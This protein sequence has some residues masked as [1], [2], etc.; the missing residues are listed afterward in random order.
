M[1]GD[2]RGACGGSG[3]SPR[4]R[5]RRRPRGVPRERHH[6]PGR[7]RRAATCQQLAGLT[8]TTAEASEAVGGRRMRPTTVPRGG[9]GRRAAARHTRVRDGRTRRTW[10]R[11][12]RACEPRASSTSPP[13]HRH[14]PP[15]RP[16]RQRS[17][18]AERGSPASEGATGKEGCD[19]TRS[20]FRS[21]PP[22]RSSIV[23]R[24][25][26]THPP[27][28]S[29]RDVARLTVHATEPTGAPGDPPARETS[30]R[31]TSIPSITPRRAPPRGD[32]SNRRGS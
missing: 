11:C 27:I 5:R 32:P 6:R 24:L 14:P 29:S 1:G 4:G 17:G 3:R 19:V 13:R 7:P 8:T 30:C 10:P 21:D 20:P 16:P 15:R 2:G 31:K 26:A 22:P 18:P 25:A 23:H 12:A 28:D 9:T